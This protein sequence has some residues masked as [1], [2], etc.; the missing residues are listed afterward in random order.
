MVD[1]VDC[2]IELI[3][4][5]FYLAAILCSS[6][7][8]NPQQR[9]FVLFKERQHP[10]IEQISRSDRGFGAIKLGKR[11][12]GTGGHK[13]LLVEPANTLQGTGI[14]EKVSCDPR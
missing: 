13:A 10:V 3:I 8:K 14:K 1:L 6:I 11:H 9:Q 5:R 2:K 4:V 12:L 7:S